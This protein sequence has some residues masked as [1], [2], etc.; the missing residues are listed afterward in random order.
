[1]GRVELLAEFILQSDLI[2]FINDSRSLVEEEILA[3]KK[4]GHVGAIL[5]L[6]S[7]AENKNH[8]LT[9]SDIKKAQGWITEEQGKKRIDLKME[10]KHIGNYRDIEIRV[11]Y[12][13]KRA[14]LEEIPIKMQELIS[15]VNYWQKI[16]KDLTE[17]Q[18]IASIA[19]FYFD[20]ETIHPFADGN[21][22]TGRAIVFYLMRYLGRDPF[23]FYA[24]DKYVMHFP[25]LRNQEPLAMRK[26]FYE[27]SGLI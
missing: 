8:F 17:E 24:E 20:F 12:T 25:A 11:E 5:Y 6:E 27:K 19:D 9:E 14:K 21:G 3:G 10:S 7:L 26:Y 16:C 22:R 15:Q 2:E 13:V 1:M 23:I 4:D 18:S